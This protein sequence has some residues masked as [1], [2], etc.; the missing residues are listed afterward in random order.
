MRWG[1]LNDCG[2]L[3]G[4]DTL[5]NEQGQKEVR[6]NFEVSEKRKRIWSVELDLL[7]KLDQICRKHDLTYFASNG[8]LLGTVR[9]KGFIPW[10]DDLD[11]MMP[12]SDYEKLIEIAKQELDKP[13]I[14]HLPDSKGQYYR[15]YLRLRNENTTAICRPD[16]GRDVCHGIFIDIFPIDVS[17]SSYWKRKEQYLKL[18]SIYTLIM[19]RTYDYK[20]RNGAVELVKGSLKRLGE[21]KYPGNNGYM[22]MIRIH[23][24]WRTKYNDTASGYYYE[25][26]HKKHIY[27]YK[28]EWLSKSVMMPFE[29]IEIP[30]PAGYNEILKS[31][32][33]DYMKLPPV[34][35]RGVHHNIFFDPDKPYSEYFGKLTREEA[36]NNENN[37]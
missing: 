5:N 25:I 26:T 13:Y 20:N 22:T 21:I 9:H 8:T 10:D 4:Y 30:V 29:D 16:F 12:R 3:Y 18:Y 37:Y 19:M 36:I 33:G 27:I 32:Y 23:D 14:L 6:C 11:V 17:P 2:G 15:N 7:K 1:C 31:L 24:E 34:D 35:E 28:K